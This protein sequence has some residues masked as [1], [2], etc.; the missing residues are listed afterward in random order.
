L[1]HSIAKAVPKGTAFVRCGVGCREAPRWSPKNELFW[2]QFGAFLAKKR[3]KTAKKGPKSGFYCYLSV[4]YAFWYA[5]HSLKL[6]R[7]LSSK[8]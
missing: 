2:R 5:V 7:F 1:V 8:K 4:T 3:P 6:T